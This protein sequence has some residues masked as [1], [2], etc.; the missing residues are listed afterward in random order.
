MWTSTSFLLLGFCVFFCVFAPPEERVYFRGW[1]IWP[2]I[3]SCRFNPAFLYKKLFKMKK[4]KG[5]VL[6]CVCI[7]GVQVWVCVCVCAEGEC[8]A[9][10]C[11]VSAVNL[12]LMSSFNVWL[13]DWERV[14]E[15]GVSLGEVVEGLGRKGEGER[16]RENI[17]CL[18]RESARNTPFFVWNVSWHKCVQ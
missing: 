14:K 15:W 1:S 10:V 11:A 5:N 7:G 8:R 9:C 18:V 2:Q 13:P 4:L 12:C 17:S 6:E 16:E 3:N